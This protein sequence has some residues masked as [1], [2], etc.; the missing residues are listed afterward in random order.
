MVQGSF[1]DVIVIGGGSAGCVIASRLSEDESRRVLLLEAG[2][3]PQPR[4]EMLTDGANGNRAILESDYVVMYPTERKAD[5]SEYYP[6][7]GRVMGGGSSVNMMAVV[8]PTQ[9]DLD[10]WARLGNPG[11]SYEECLPFIRR[12]ESDQEFGEQPHHG[13]DGPLNVVHPAP[14]ATIGPGLIRSFLDRAVAVGLPLRDDWNVPNPEGI[15]R[16]S[17]NVK[18]GIRQS[19]AV[20]YLDP[21]RGRPNLTIA[22]EAQVQSLTIE[23][24]R[25]SGVVYERDGVMETASAETVVL[26][27]GVYHSPQILMLSGIGP[28]DHLK[29][30]GIPVVHA[31]PGVGQNYQDHANVTLTFEGAEGFDPDWMLPGFR[32]TYKSDASL[33]N[34]DFH[35]FMRA[36]VIIEG[37]RPMIPITANLIEQRSRGRVYLGSTNPRDL[38][39]IDDGL[40]QDPG[41][42]AA[43]LRAMRFIHELVDDDSLRAY[44]G[45]LMQPGPEEDWEEFALTTYDCYH[46]GAGTCKMGQASDGMAVVDGTLKVHGL[47]NL[48]VADA[49][50]MPTVTHA[51][52]NI[53][54][55][56]IGERLTDFL[57]EASR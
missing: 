18:D 4:P 3:D 20:A 38:P 22:A 5:G 32:L 17:Q 16:A 46:H 23:G 55:I 12:I 45:P 43:A 13:S 56:M 7:A 28:E 11:W 27:A 14:L 49:S 51:N 21:A 53:T 6:L 2:P 31:L 48:Y 30:M 50:I 9:H 15:V 37:L 25:V 39:I 57:K 35:I 33:P 26:S 10:T 44:F 47:D 34:A 24:S 52:T 41:D 54:A 19:T 36:P 40:L 29:E 1:Y 8:H 42:I